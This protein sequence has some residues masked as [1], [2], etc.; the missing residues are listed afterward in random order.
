[1]NGKHAAKFWLLLACT[2]LVVSLFASSVNFSVETSSDDWIVYTHLHII[3]PL[4]G[5]ATPQGYSPNQIRAAYNLPS[6]GGAGTTIAV[7]IAYHCPT[8]W[9]DLTMFSRQFNLPLPTNSNF[10]V[11]QMGTLTN[12]QWAKE[13]ALDVEWATR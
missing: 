2:L 1:V 3:N 9:N 6:S 13:A 8:I 10:I 4:A 7:I 5:S 12:S 11:N